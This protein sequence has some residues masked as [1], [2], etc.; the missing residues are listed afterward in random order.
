MLMC[1]PAREVQCNVNVE[2]S[3]VNVER[4]NVNVQINIE[5]FHV[6][7]EQVYLW[8]L[9]EVMLKLNVNAGRFNA[10]VGKVQCGLNV[11]S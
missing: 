1:R 8:F 3:N 4:F 7:I 2:K 9:R 10:D 6:H 11:D 5:L